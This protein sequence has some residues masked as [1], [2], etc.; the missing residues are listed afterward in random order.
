M[1]SGRPRR[2]LVGAKPSTTKGRTLLFC[3][4]DARQPSPWSMLRPIQPRPP[5]QWTKKAPTAG[6]HNLLSDVSR[7]LWP[8]GAWAR[9]PL[10]VFLRPPRGGATSS[11]VTL[12]FNCSATLYSAPSPRHTVD[13]P[14]FQSPHLP[15]PKCQSPL[16]RPLP[17]ARFP[18]RPCPPH[19]CPDHP[20]HTIH[21]ALPR[22][23]AAPPTQDGGTYVSVSASRSTG[24][25]G[26]ATVRCFL[27][28]ATAS[29]R[30]HPRTQHR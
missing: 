22:N 11:G 10:F 23:P 3:T 19:K 15:R 18:V 2:T 30:S 4:S 21:H 14:S 16:W 27:T 7:S 28:C 13:A 26:T 17:P 12:S 20:S 25:L 9:V 24:T 6:C 1:G 29:S 8:A 5:A